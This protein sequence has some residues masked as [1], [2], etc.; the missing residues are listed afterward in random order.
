MIQ[1][2]ID[3]WDVVRHLEDHGDEDVMDF[4]LAIDADRSFGFT[5]RLIDKLQEVIDHG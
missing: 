3:E 4:I 1:I 2:Q 5:E